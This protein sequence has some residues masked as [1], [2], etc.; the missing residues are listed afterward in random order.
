MII[1][2]ELARMDEFWKVVYHMFLHRRLNDEKEDHTKK[3]LCKLIE[4]QI[5]NSKDIYGR[6]CVQNR[7]DL[8]FLKILRKEIV[9]C[10]LRE[11]QKELKFYPIYY[12]YYLS[13]VVGNTNNFKTKWEPI[14]KTVEEI[15]EIFKQ[16][17][18]SYPYSY[19][20]APT[21]KYELMKDHNTF[22]TYVKYSETVG[23]VVRGLEMEIEK[24]AN[25]FN[26]VDKYWAQEMLELGFS[27][28]STS[29]VMKTIKTTVE[30]NWI[31]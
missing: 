25:R 27:I 13:P 5:V 23:K 10:M 28:K 20:I 30:N 8:R 14:C 4:R 1:R 29:I 22:A 15:Y 24:I 21:M 31:T 9:A 7:D 3:K 26:S 11:R 2:G 18:K 16:L 12:A 19:T 6:K 17:D